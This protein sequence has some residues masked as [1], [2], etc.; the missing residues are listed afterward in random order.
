MEYTLVNTADPLY[1]QAV[2]LRYEVF[3]K[4]FNGGWDNI[5][6][7]LEEKALHLVCVEN[8]QVFGYGRLNL[9]NEDTAVISQMVVAEN[10]RHLGIGKELMRLLMNLAQE[11]GRTMAILNAR[12]EAQKFYEKLGFHREGDI[13]PSKKTGLPHVKMVKKLI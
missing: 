7:D 3:F 8:N 2:E 13:F 4:P 6:D 11:Q 10:L 9:V 12:V 5:Y 1:R